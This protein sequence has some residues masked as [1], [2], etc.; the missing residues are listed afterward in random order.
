MGFSQPPACNV[1][2]S[3]ALVEFYISANGPNWTYN[4]NWLTS[5]V[6]NWYGI[7]LTPDTVI[8]LPY[9][10]YMITL[11]N[12]NMTGIISPLLCQ[13]SQLSLL[14]LMNNNLTGSIPDCIL[15]LDNF[16]H[17]A[18]DNNNL[19]GPLP[20][21]SHCPIVSLRIPHNEFIGDISDSLVNNHYFNSFVI[22]N[23]HFSSIPPQDSI[24]VTN[25]FFD[26]SSNHF[27][28]KDVLFYAVNYSLCI[29]S[30][31][32]SVLE[33]YDTTILQGSSLVLGSWVD[34]CQDNRYHWIKDGTYV[35]PNPVSSNQYIK[36][37]VQFSDSGYYSCDISNIHAPDLVLHRRLIKVQVADTTAGIQYHNK[38]ECFIQYNLNEKHLYIK[39]NL[40]KEQQLKCY[41]YDISG[42]K[43]L[44]L[45]E[46]KVQL[47]DLHFYL[48]SIH[49]KS[50]T[51]FVR[52]ECENINLVKKIILP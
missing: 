9:H 28:F 11:I 14:V 33:S 36:N 51:Y 25:T 10:V 1:N 38:P 39:I 21:F 23:N 32:D 6:F 13:L 34:T 45:Y 3:L 30:P 29:Y 17:L 16:M 15:D 7:A 31:Q 35:T 12:N 4:T 27:T 46:G 22:N 42:R 5:P 18:L 2:D 41:L 8:D 40:K 48:D 20:S 26:L 49:I 44:R 52:L 19:S 50:G 24:L 43:V 37:N 47:Q